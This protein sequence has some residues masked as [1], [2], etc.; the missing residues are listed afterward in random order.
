MNTGSLAMFTAIRAS[1]R[2][3]NLAAEQQI[4]GEIID[5]GRGEVD[6]GEYREIARVAIAANISTRQF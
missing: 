1:S 2:V 3:K 6:C 5:A 4:G